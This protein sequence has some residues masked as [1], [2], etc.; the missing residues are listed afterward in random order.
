MVSTEQF[1]DFPGPSSNTLVLDGRG[2]GSTAMTLTVRYLDK[3]TRDG[4]IASGM[5]EGLGRGYERLDDV[6]DS[7]LGNIT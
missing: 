5:T 4:W 1:D 6:L 7:V 2:D 3:Q